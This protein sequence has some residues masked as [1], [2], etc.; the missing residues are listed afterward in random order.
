MR[1]KIKLPPSVFFAA[2]FA[3]AIHPS[4]YFSFLFLF[5][6]GWV[7][8]LFI[9]KVLQSQK[10]GRVKFKIRV[11]KYTNLVVCFSGSLSLPLRS[12]ME[13]ER[14]PDFAK[15]V[16]KFAWLELSVSEQEMYSTSIESKICSKKIGPIQCKHQLLE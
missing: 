13:R 14:G 10:Q 6:L 11:L 7:K 2:A 4:V 3:A 12:C 9:F 16:L 1:R 5:H 8:L 15:S